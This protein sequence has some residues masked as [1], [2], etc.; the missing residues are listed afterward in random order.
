MQA[1]GAGDRMFMHQPASGDRPHLP[2]TA[3]A[4]AWPRSADRR[5]RLSRG[6]AGLQGRSLHI[7]QWQAAE[8]PKRFALARHILLGQT[9]EAL[10]M[11]PAVLADGELNRED[12]QTWPLFDPLREL[13]A[14]QRLLA[15]PRARS[16]D[17]S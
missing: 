5:F 15:D 8:L 17:A 3:C 9:G 4:L 13:P 2:P 14:F 16:S 11:L 7:S 12:L 10:A 1:G 6:C